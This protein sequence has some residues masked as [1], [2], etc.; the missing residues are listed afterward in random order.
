MKFKPIPN[1]FEADLIH[2]RAWR[3]VPTT[4]ILGGLLLC[5]V[6]MYWAFTVDGWQKIFGGLL[7]GGV[8]LAYVKA[9]QEH[10]FCF[11]EDMEKRYRCMEKQ[12]T[13]FICDATLGAMEED[14]LRRLRMAAYRIGAANNEKLSEDDFTLMSEAMYFWNNQNG[15]RWQDEWECQN[16]KM[17]R[18]EHAKDG[19]C[20]GH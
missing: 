3:F 8:V 17:R 13:A 20:L 9:M 6:G 2:S 14:D 11:R 5:A 7:A 4:E 12:F 1:S 18:I 19:T 15:V 10:L 16:C